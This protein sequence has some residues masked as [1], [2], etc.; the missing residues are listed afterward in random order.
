MKMNQKSQSQIITTVLII[1]LVLDAIVIVWQVVS[2]TVSEGAGE[3]SSSISCIDVQFKVVEAIAA[4][5]TVKVTRM[6]GGADNAVSDVRFLVNGEVQ[7]HD[8]VTGGNDL[9]ALETKTYTLSTA[10]A[11]T[12]GAK[13]EA[14]AV[15]SDGKVC[16]PT[17]SITAVA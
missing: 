3:I 15:L 12:A 11:I 13:V 1:L 4:S 8:P 17:A 6:A 14:A 2:T 7:S 5:N 16:N 9:Q 10:G